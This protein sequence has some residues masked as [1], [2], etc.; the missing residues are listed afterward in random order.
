MKYTSKIVFVTFGLTLVF[1]ASLMFAVS[2]EANV[3]LTFNNKTDVMVSVA[4]AWQGFDESHSKGWFNIKPRESRTITL[5]VAAALTVSGT[6][7]HARAAGGKLVWKG[8]T[9]YPIRLKEAFEYVFGNVVP[10]GSTLVGFR[11]IKLKI[12]EDREEGWATVNLTR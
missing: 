10:R 11:N 9:T 5:N 6:Y 7:Y 8:T 4:L 3:K 2:A 1:W 12:S